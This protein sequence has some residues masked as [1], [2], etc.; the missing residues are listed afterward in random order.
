MSRIYTLITKFN[1]VLIFIGAIIFIS[2]L[3]Y[4]FYKDFSRERYEPPKVKVVDSLESETAVVEPIYKLDFLTSIK[5]VYVFKLK[6]NVVQT[7]SEI[8]AVEVHLFAGGGDYY[9]ASPV[10]LMFARDDGSTRFLLDKHAFIQDFSLA[11]DTDSEFGHKQALNLYSIVQ[12]DSN[13]DGFLDKNDSKDLYA[14]NYDGSDLVS[15]FDSYDLIDDDMIMVSKQE[16]EESFYIFN[17]A[18]S[19]SFKINTDLP[20]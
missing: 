8:E 15:G 13:G 16:G 19:T 1:Q 7:S 11:K 6:S 4:Q 2:F 18:D 14:S 12:Q 5:D 9:D 20:F 17:L 10:N 3:S